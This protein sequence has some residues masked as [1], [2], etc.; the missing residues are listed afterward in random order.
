MQACHTGNSLCGPC[1]W[2]FLI[3]LDYAPNRKPGTEFVEVQFERYQR[4]YGATPPDL[5]TADTSVH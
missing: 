3:F 4:R 5:G 1:T 2:N